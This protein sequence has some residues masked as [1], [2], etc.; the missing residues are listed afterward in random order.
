MYTL[1]QVAFFY[2]IYSGHL[3]VLVYKPQP[4]FN[5]LIGFMIRMYHKL[6]KCFA[7][8]RCSQAWVSFCSALLYKQYCTE[9]PCP[10]ILAWGGHTHF[11]RHH[12]RIRGQCLKEDLAV[13]VVV[14]S[15]LTSILVLFIL[16]GPPM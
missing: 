11:R 9:H 7:S 15:H 4:L 16:Q 1:L 12:P 14:C 13:M 10:Q 3:S 6:F 8:V 5:S 2:L